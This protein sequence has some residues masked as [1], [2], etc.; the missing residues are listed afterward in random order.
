MLNRRLTAPRSELSNGNQNNEGE[1]FMKKVSKY[2]FD[3]H[4]VKDAMA[5]CSPLLCMGVASTHV[6]SAKSADDL[7]TWCSGTTTA[8]TVIM[9][10]SQL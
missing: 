1:Y 9:V 7:D 6:F 8:L 10:A 3:V 4:L 2:E 5:I